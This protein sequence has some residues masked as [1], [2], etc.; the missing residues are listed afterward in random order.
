[1]KVGIFCSSREN[2]AE[3]YFERTAE[4]GRWLAKNGHSIVFGGSDQGL[5]E[6][7]AKAARQAGGR[8][9]GVVPRILEQRARVSDNVDV[10][11]PCDDLSDRKALI[12][13]QSDVFIALPG[14]VGTLDELFSVVAMR[15]IGYH[16][17]EILCYDINGFWQPLATMLDQLSTT[18]VLRPR[19]RDT[20]HFV[21]N[22]D[23]MG[24]FIR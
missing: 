19:W 18:G 12:M 17:K 5:M 15:Q 16:T 6:C 11:I 24:D 4:L 3:E 20:I 1:M 21:K 14:G 9:I 13:A 10:L 22:I 2:I 7:V 23:E 8:T